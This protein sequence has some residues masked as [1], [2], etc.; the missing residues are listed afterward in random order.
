VPII[1]W[2]VRPVLA[3]APFIGFIPVRD[4]FEARGFYQRVLGLRVVEDTPFALVLDANGTMLRVTPVPDLAVQSFT[5]AGWQVDDIAATV[6][7]LEAKGVA[8]PGTT[9]WARTSS[10]SGRPRVE[11]RSPGSPIPPATPSP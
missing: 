8:S 6:Q 9:A 11:T 5:I 7:A 2:Y 10:A 3:A 1:A 4:I